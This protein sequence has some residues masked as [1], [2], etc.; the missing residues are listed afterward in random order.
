[1]R[2]AKEIA[3]T[4]FHDTALAGSRALDA[5]TGP[6]VTASPRRAVPPVPYWP[7]DAE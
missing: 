6:V 1:M 5:P 7:R 3:M 2:L 4:R